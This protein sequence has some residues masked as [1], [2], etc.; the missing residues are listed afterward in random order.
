MG[1][2]IDFTRVLR[3]KKLALALSE[4]NGAAPPMIPAPETIG[5]EVVERAEDGK[6]IRYMN[7]EK[8]AHMGYLPDNP[9][10]VFLDYN[11]QCAAYEE[12]DLDYFALAIELG[13]LPEPIEIINDLFEEF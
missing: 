11:H 8:R 3:D 13:V 5:W 6:P 4:F 7:F 1:E 9:D 12:M 10:F 2:L